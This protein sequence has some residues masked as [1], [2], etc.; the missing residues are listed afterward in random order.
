VPCSYP[1]GEPPHPD[2]LCPRSTPSTG[3]PTARFERI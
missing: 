1:P 2:R 3:Y